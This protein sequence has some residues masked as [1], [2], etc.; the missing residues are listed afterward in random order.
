MNG[1]KEYEASSSEMETVFTDAKN[2]SNEQIKQAKKLIKS[3]VDSMMVIPVDMV[4][5]DQRID[6]ENCCR[7]GKASGHHHQGCTGD[8]DDVC[9]YEPGIPVDFSCV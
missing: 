9:G 8:R 4:A 1:V 7:S 2:N 5:A 3:G 6:S